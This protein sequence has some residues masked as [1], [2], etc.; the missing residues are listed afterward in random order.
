MGTHEETERGTARLTT[1]DLAGPGGAG[2][3]PDTGPPVFPGDATGEDLSGR[4]AGGGREDEGFAAADGSDGADGLGPSDRL[5]DRP[6][7]RSPV[8]ADGS[9]DGQ[10]LLAS[11][12]AEHFRTAWSEIQGRFVDDPR[13]AVTSADTLVAEVMRSLAGTFASH[14][15]DLEGQWQRGDDVAT[16]DLRQAL[17]HYRSFFNRLL[18]A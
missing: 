14:K 11:G 12:D 6:A 13:E 18:N 4:S 8:E 7:A 1:E 2:R 5:D 15:Q 9:G 10:P 17:R 16:E 3:G